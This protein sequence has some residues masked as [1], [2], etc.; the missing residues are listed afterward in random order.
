MEMVLK[1]IALGP[2]GYIKDGFNVFDGVIVILSYIS[3][4]SMVLKRVY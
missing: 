3:D 2:F 1:L 4:T